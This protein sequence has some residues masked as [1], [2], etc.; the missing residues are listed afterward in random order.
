MGRRRVRAAVPKQEIYF[1]LLIWQ[2]IDSVDARCE[3]YWWGSV[4]GGLGTAALASGRAEHRSRETNE[5]TETQIRDKT[6]EK[7]TSISSDGEEA[8]LWDGHRIHSRVP[9]GECGGNKMA[10]HYFK[11]DFVHRVKL[12]LTVGGWGQEL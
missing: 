4:V 3:V 8:G 10:P 1:C 11:S 9:S 7:Y 2:E 12:I 5:Q 6:I